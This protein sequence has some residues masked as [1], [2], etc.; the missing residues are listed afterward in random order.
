MT[1]R[2]KNPPRRMGQSGN[3]LT[4]AL[5]PSE[6]RCIETEDMG[7]KRAGDMGRRERVR[8]V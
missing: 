5:S 6:W 3:S 7:N 2:M 8:V 4:L 1:G